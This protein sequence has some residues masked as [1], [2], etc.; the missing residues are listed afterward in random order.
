VTIDLQEFDALRTMFPMQCKH[1]IS[2]RILRNTS[3]YITDDPLKVTGYICKHS[4]EYA[5]PRSWT[6]WVT[7]NGL[8]D[9]NVF[10]MTIVI[11]GMLRLHIHT[12]THD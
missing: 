5:V 2:V 8:R 4:S 9:K 11:A 12:A 10:I 6:L 1:L 7:N 3:M